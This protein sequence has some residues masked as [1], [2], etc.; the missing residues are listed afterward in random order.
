[1]QKVLTKLFASNIN[2]SLN[3]PSLSFPNTPV[4]TISA[5]Y[6][7][8]CSNGIAATVPLIRLATSRHAKPIKSGTEKSFA[9][10]S[11]SPRVTWGG[12]GGGEGREGGK[13]EKQGEGLKKER[14]KERGETEKEGER[15]EVDNTRKEGRKPSFLD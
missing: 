5:E 15:R 1:M 13:E 9:S 14:R 2:S 3:F 8:N 11:L 10:D 12:G 6:L 4:R 7:W